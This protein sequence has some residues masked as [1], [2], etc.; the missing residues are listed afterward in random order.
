MPS[1]SISRDLFRSFIHEQDQQL[2]IRVVARHTLQH[3][4]QQHGLA[5][6]GG[7]HDQRALPF[8]EWGDQVDHSVGVVTSTSALEPAFEHHVLVGIGGG[9]RTEVRPSA[10]FL[11]RK[12]VHAFDAFQWR[13]LAAPRGR[14]GHSRDLVAGPQPEA[15]DQRLRN[16]YVIAG[17]LEPIAGGA[18]KA[19]ATGESLENSLCLSQSS[20]SGAATGSG[21][22]GCSHTERCDGNGRAELRIGINLQGD[23]P[24]RGCREMMESPKIQFACRNRH[25]RENQPMRTG[26]GR[27]KRRRCKDK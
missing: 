22:S 13:A 17:S 20:R 11:R 3:G 24:P 10:C 21:V 9:E 27:D 19:A 23:D 16:E 26:P 6:S 25:A 8:A 18:E 1:I 7:R 2:R 14:A 15:A 5:R 12:P 4:L